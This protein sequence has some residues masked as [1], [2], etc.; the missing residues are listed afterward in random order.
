MGEILRPVTALLLSVAIL[1]LGNGL[2][3]F[4]IPLSRGHREFYRI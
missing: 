2:Q 3:I 1:L 4:I